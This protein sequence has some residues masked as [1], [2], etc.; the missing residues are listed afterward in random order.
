MDLHTG[1]STCA[2]RDEHHMRAQEAAAD[3][4]ISAISSMYAQGKI[5]ANQLYGSRHKQ[6]RAAA[7][8]GSRYDRW[9]A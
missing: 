5:V 1:K 8:G 2:Q 6:L 9:K 3:R 7:L 4:R